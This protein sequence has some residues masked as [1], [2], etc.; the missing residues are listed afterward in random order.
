MQKEIRSAI[1]NFLA[2]LPPGRLLDMPSGS[3]WLG[4]ELSSPG[5]Q[6]SPADLY[7]EA[8]VPGFK[9]ADLNEGAPF[10]DGSFDYV[11]CLEGLEHI[12]NYHFVLREF[13]R[14]LKPGG[15]LLISTPNPLN[16][17]SR[18]RYLLAG[19]FWG[20]PHLV[21]LP[22]EG[23]HLHMTPVNISF[24]IAFAKRYG[25]VLNEVHRVQ[26]KAKNYRFIPVALFLKA[27]ALVK[28]CLKEKKHKD[29][30]D[31][32]FSLNILLN[33]GMVVSFKKI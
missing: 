32:L 30:M 17:K 28:F 26:P 16:I 33:D 2:G 5:W 3:C 29:F 4:K 18:L 31:V 8:G 23:S 15:M 14:V 24:L 27:Y 22:P 11:A 25:L 20:F 7:A 10:E 1:L 6:Y 12:E 21:E 9:K 13:S 19:T